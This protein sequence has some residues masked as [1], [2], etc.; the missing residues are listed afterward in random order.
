M[1]IRDP[2]DGMEPRSTEKSCGELQMTDLCNS[3]HYTS[4]QLPFLIC[5]NASKPGGKGGERWE[6]GRKKPLI[7]TGIKRKLQH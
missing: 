5:V 1:G 3:E 6:G 2:D 7:T 4:E